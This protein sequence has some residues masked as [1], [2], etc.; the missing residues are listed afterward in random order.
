M[1][2]RVAFPLVLQSPSTGAAI[3]GAT[4]TVTKHVVGAGTLGAG[5]AA[6][7]YAQE[8]GGVP[9]TGNQIVTDNLGRWTQGSSAGYAAYWLP[10]GT[11]DIAIS[12]PGL[13]AFTIV[14][15]LVSGEVNSDSGLELQANKGE[16]SGY[17][18]LNSSGQV[19]AAQLPAGQ[20]S[21]VASLDTNTHVPFAQLGA[22]APAFLTASGAVAIPAGAG[23]M[24]VHIIGG[25]QAGEEGT[26]AAP[27]GYGGN[28]GLLVSQLVSLSG[29]SGLYFTQGAGGTTPAG[30]GATS[31]LSGTG[32]TT[33]SASGG[34]YGGVE[35]G[36][37]PTGLQIGSWPAVGGVGAD[38]SN[39]GGN[40]GSGSGFQSGAGGGGGWSGNVAGGGG[41][42]GFGSGGAGGDANLN[43]GN[44]TGYGAGGGGGGGTSGGAIT[45]GGS[46]TPGCCLIQWL[47]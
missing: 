2:N 45:A 13:S 10:Q 1:T 5:A 39:D 34:V 15:E 22:L 37:Y 32:M 40:G 9:I 30:E 38:P 24:I 21:G 11:Y 3:I 46:G 7:I 28:P 44:A 31:S 26:D 23:H 8:V 33:I 14:R 29:V 20:A 35:M 6:S 12:G 16:P 19:P 36:A 25:G 42:G 27:A 43:G 17:A 4:A 18:G 41:A 47:P